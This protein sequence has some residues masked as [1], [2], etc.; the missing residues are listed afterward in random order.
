MRTSSLISAYLRNA[1]P[2]C[3]DF[4]PRAN[5]Y[6]TWTPLTA[7]V[8]TGRYM[9]HR[10]GSVPYATSRARHPRALMGF[11]RTLTIATVAFSTSNN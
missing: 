9:R 11:L 1:L 4:R 10:H 2:P 8:G 3:L 6:S 7:Q 5:G